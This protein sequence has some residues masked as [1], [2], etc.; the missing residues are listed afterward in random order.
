MMAKAFEQIPIKILLKLKT[1]VS[2]ITEFFYPSAGLWAC[3][4]IYYIA[5]QKSLQ[6]SYILLKCI[7]SSIIIMLTV[8]R[9][10]LNIVSI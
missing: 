8:M 7:G 3:R 10:I 6:L 9:C 4:S 2:K 1:I 5:Q